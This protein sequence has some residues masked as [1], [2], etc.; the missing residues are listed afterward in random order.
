M[1]L[2]GLATEQANQNLSNASTEIEN[3]LSLVYK[4]QKY[5]AFHNQSVEADYSYKNHLKMAWLVIKYNQ[6]WLPPHEENVFYVE[7]G[8]IIKFGRVRFKVR[9][10]KINQHTPEESS[11]GDVIRH[12]VNVEHEAARSKIIAD[13]LVLEAANNQSIDPDDFRSQRG[14]FVS[15]TTH[16]DTEVDMNNLGRT[17]ENNNFDRV[18]RFDDGSTIDVDN[19][20]NES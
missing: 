17:E 1:E 3:L 2:P 5:F 15:Q 8:D 13:K 10:L 11:M 7:K 14:S 16:F 9:E 12:D 20:A 4:N 18:R 19:E 6:D